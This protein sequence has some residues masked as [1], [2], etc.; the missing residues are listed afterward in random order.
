MWDATSRSALLETL[1]EKLVGWGFETNPY[2]W[3]VANKAINGKQCTV[4]WHVDDLKISHKDKRKVTNLI[5]DLKRSL[6]KRPT[7]Q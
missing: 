5:Q 1:S 7:L 3:C 2:D 6:E 4:R